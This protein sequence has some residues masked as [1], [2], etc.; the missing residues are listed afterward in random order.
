M[1]IDRG[2]PNYGT[3]SAAST[4]AS[5]IA[6][7]DAG[8][9]YTGT[10]VE[11]VLAEISDSHIENTSNP[12]NVTAAQA[13]APSL[14]NLASTSNGQGASLVG[15]ED[16][17]GNYTATDV[18]A[19]L[20]EVYSSPPEA[21]TVASTGEKYGQLLTADG[22]NS[23]AWS[24]LVWKDLKGTYRP[25]SG[26][27]LPSPTLFI[28][29]DIDERLYAAGDGGDFFFHMPHDYAVGTDIYMH[30]HWGH[31]GTGISGTLAL[32]FEITYA[33]RA[34]SAPFS[35]FSTPITPTLAN[36]ATVNITNYP[37]Y[38]HV[39]EEFQLS[40]GT[41]TATQLDT[42]DLAV[43]GVVLCHLVATTVPT[44]TGGSAGIF[45]F[46]VDIHYQADVYGTKNK[47]PNYYS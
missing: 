40:A 23:S 18:E 9:N 5:E 1:A 2:D 7:T 15:I 17:A 31:N 43:D 44:V 26:A 3:G 21:N 20:A 47:D 4:D 29:A 6:V 25:D 41:P 30:V 36:S 12:H 46:G 19:A 16:S 24:Q 28:G 27:A 35:A 11:T 13:G 33:N 37:Q 38:C 10:N 22:A 45:I 42:D 14:T 39:V 8:S 32:N 34:A